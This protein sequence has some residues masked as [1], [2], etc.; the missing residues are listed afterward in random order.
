MIQWVL[1][2]GSS[3]N[4]LSQFLSKKF[5]LKNLSLCAFITAKFLRDTI[6]RIHVKCLLSMV[7]IWYE[8]IFYNPARFPFSASQRFHLAM[9]QGAHLSRVLA[10]APALTPSIAPA[11]G[12]PLADC[13]MLPLVPL[14][15]AK[16]PFVPYSAA[17]VSVI[18][19][20]SH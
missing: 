18:G 1:E 13:K 7:L 15:F 3:G 4:N 12:L 8:R 10:P 14:F 5:F 20:P 19:N 16:P 6:I 2:R 17:L 9:G 11:L